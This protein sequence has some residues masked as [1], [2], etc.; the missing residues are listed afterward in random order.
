MLVSAWGWRFPAAWWQEVVGVPGL[1]V[2]AV[3]SDSWSCRVLQD[4]LC[5]CRQETLFPPAAWVTWQDWQPGGDA[6]AAAKSCSG[7]LA[8]ES[9][10]KLFCLPLRQWNLI[11]VALKLRCQ[12]WLVWLTGHYSCRWCCFVSCV[13]AWSADIKVVVTGGLQGQS[14]WG[15]AGHVWLLNICVVLSFWSTP[16]PSEAPGWNCWHGFYFCVKT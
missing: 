6:V 9:E 1:G 12:D 5:S 16:C 7:E 10:I 3:L 14:P 4:R 11:F 2:T 15:G 8:F 13:N